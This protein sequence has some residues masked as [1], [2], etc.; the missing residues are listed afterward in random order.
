MSDKVIIAVRTTGDQLV[1]VRPPNPGDPLMPVLGSS[2]SCCNLIT[3][4]VV[5]YGPIDQG[6]KVRTIY[7]SYE[8]FLGTLEDAQKVAEKM[9]LD[10]PQLLSMS[11]SFYWRKKE[12]E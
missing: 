5:D 3:S 7:S 6:W 12:D 4:K 1:K 10:G 11:L 9:G 2:Y 8:F